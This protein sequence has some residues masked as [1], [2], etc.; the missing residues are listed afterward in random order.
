MPDA[1]SL[2]AITFIINTVSQ[3][4]HRPFSISQPVLLRIMESPKLYLSS[5]RLAS[6]SV[7]CILT[8]L[9]VYTL[10]VIIIEGEY[11][12]KPDPRMDLVMKVQTLVTSYSHRLDLENGVQLPFPSFLFKRI[13]CV[14]DSSI[15]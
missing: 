2:K 10:A 13:I 14:D 1:N 5:L 9:Y 12:S 11:R 3:L 8:L 4:A 15:L 7:V 6:L